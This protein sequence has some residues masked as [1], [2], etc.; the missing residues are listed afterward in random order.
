MPGREPDVMVVLGKKQAQVKP[1]YLDGPADI[2]IEIVSPESRAR[3]Y[4][5]KFAEYARAGVPEY[6][7]IDPDTNTVA[8]YHLGAD[9][10][11][12]PIPVGPDAIF[13]SEELPAFWLNTNWLEQDPL[14]TIMSVLK[15]WGM[16]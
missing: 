15:E 9:G 5:I 14:P 11:Y 1:T 16:I 6:W 7:I 8:F 10:G 4:Q 3:D 12:H 2:T 13:R